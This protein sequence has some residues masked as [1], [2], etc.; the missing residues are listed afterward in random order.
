MS[1][2]VPHFAVKTSV[3]PTDE[4]LFVLVK[5]NACDAH[6]VETQRLRTGENLAFHSEE[7]ESRCCLRHGHTV[8]SV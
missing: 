3:E 6:G 2:H 5:L 8:W 1:L 4:M 7:I